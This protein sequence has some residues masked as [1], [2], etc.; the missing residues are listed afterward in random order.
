MEEF[1]YNSTVM[2]KQTHTQTNELEDLEIN[3][4]EQNDLYRTL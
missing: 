4:L 2:Y 1:E 3:R